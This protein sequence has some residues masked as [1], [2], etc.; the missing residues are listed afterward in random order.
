MVR[1]SR[2]RSFARSIAR[3]DIVWCL[4][5]V[6]GIQF[7]L[8]V[9]LER[10]RPELRDPEYGH[11][12][13][14]LRR[15]TAE[16]PDRPLLVALGSSRTL[17][18]LRPELHD[19]TDPLVFNFGLT[20]HGPILQ[21][22]ALDRLLRDGVKPRFATIE[23]LPV[24][25]PQGEHELDGTPAFRQSWSDLQCLSQYGFSRPERS[26]SW[27]EARSAPAYTSRFVLMS[28]LAPDWVPWKN[29]QD[30]VWSSTDHWGWLASHVPQTAAANAGLASQDLTAMREHTIH[31]ES[32]RAVRMT[33]ERLSAEH[34][35]AAIVLM[36]EASWF[37]GAM[38][39]DRAAKLSEFARSLSDENG[40]LLIDARDWCV[41]DEFLPDGHHLLPAGAE[42]FTK[43]YDRDVLPRLAGPRV[44]IR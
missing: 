15:V 2:R 41:D 10:W 18:G 27:L 26:W 14:L 12:L 32:A 35:E 13:Q 17:N 43:R 34:I 25:L 33:L 30:F 36:P 4:A 31:P 40:V 3:R 5:G 28:R 9:A 39:P 21:L 29:R 16:N 23:L 37:R 8:A 20:R 38:P 44:A 22:L 19:A 1:R 24:L 6:I 42:R 7:V 11:K